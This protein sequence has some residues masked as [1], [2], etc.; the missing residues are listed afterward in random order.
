MTS[1]VPAADLS[2]APPP[3]PRSTTPLLLKDKRCQHAVN[4]G[5]LQRIHSFLTISSF[6]RACLPMRSRR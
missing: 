5:A 4:G 3:P 1:H 2:A 6:R